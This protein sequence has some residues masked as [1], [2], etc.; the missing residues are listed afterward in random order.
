MGYWGDDLQ[1]WDLQWK[2]NRDVC[3]DRSIFLD[4]TGLYIILLPETTL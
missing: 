1:R 4:K 3:N 2:K